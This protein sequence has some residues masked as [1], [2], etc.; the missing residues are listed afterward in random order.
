MLR[1]FGHALIVCL[2]LAVHLVFG[3]LHPRA[4]CGQQ[5][6][7]GA[8]GISGWSK[9]RAGAGLRVRVGSMRVPALKPLS[10]GI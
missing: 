7:P 3:C 1:G 4:V 2:L 10:T 5:E 6:S 9:E 8:S